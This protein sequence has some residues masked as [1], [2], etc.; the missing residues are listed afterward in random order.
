MLYPIKF[1]PIYKSKVWG[2]NKIKALKNENNIPDKCGE[3]WELSGV[4]GDVSVVKNGFLKDNTIEE[5]IEVYMGDMVGDKIFEKFAYEFPILLK[6]IEANENLSI[7]VHPDDATAEQRHNARGKSEAWYILETLHNA[8]LI[9]GFNKN[10]NFA[11]MSDLIKLKNLETIL[12]QPLTKPSEV[13]YIPSGRVHSLGK[14]NLIVEIQQTSDVT[15]RIYD[16]DRT[17]RELHLDLASD[18]IDYKKT[19][20]LTEDYSR[21]PDKSNKILKNSNFTINYL[22]VM[23]SLEK[24]YFNIDSFI[25][26]YCIKGELIIKYNNKTETLKTGETVLIPAALKNI[27]LI[28]K[29]YTEMLE[30]Y[31]EL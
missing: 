15:Y 21:N 22:P 14:G 20:K 18:V 27:V 30:I 3:S 28:P 9:S 8:K 26:Y 17:D 1:Y 25:I 23:N 2:G 10:S 5:I 11:E 6:I 13:Y 24:D 7:Q 29:T 19:E 4:E 12:N 16:Y 31:L